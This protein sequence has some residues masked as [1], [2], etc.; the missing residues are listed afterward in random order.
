MTDVDDASKWT[1]ALIPARA[2]AVALL[3]FGAVGF[4]G[5]MRLAHRAVRT[6]TKRWKVRSA[7]VRTAGRTLECTEEG[8]TG[9]EAR[10]QI[11]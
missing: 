11:V 1:A 4:V 8:D 2:Y 3:H 5:V 10:R 6:L 9:D 7:F